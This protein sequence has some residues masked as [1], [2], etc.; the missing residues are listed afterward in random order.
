M[1]NSNAKTTEEDIQT[2]SGISGVVSYA[3]SMLSMKNK[4]IA[5]ILISWSYLII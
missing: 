2:K 4:Q 5:F 1:Q 3:K